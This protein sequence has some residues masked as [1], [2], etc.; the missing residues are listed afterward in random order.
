M[1]D[2]QVPPFSP[3]IVMQDLY[4]FFGHSPLSSQLTN[5]FKKNAYP[6]YFSVFFPLLTSPQQVSLAE[7]LL[8]L[9]QEKLTIRLLQKA[10]ETEGASAPALLLLAKAH[11]GQGDL[12]RAISLAQSAELLEP[13]NTDALRFLAES[14]ARQGRYNEEL[15]YLEKLKALSPAYSAPE[16]GSSPF[17]EEAEVGLALL[18]AAAT[19]G[20]GREE[21]ALQL[22]FRLDFEMPED[23]E[24]RPLV[25]SAI[26]DIALS[27]GKLDVAERYTEKELQARPS[28]VP[29]AQMRMGHIRLLGGD[30][31][32]SIGH[33]TEFINTYVQQN[34]G[35]ANIALSKLNGQWTLLRKK[36]IGE[37]DLQLI[38]DILQASANGTL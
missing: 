9:G 22:Y 10:I 11:D 26:A 2:A 27:L 4:R 13:K 30:W 6:A 18:I 23:A 37:T 34:G 17:K 14:Y 1:E 8:E 12:A 28:G 31:K 19:A 29:E 32:G 25:Y 24:S 20:A 21:E 15:E 7:L 3:R 5:P 35:D 16:G 38:H 36:G 33:Y